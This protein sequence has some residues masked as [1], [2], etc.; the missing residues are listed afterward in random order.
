MA[1][2]PLFTRKFDFGFHLHTPIPDNADLRE[3]DRDILSSNPI[4]KAMKA[5][6]FEVSWQLQKEGQNV[7]SGTI[8]EKDLN[9]RV[10]ALDIQYIFAKR[11]VLLRKGQNYML[12][13]EVT[14]PSQALAAFS[15]ELLIRTWASL[16]GHL[17]V[18]WKMRDTMLCLALGFVL[19]AAGLLRQYSEG[20]RK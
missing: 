9:H 1:F 11:N 4:E 18:G 17:L 16:K 12:V 3:P 10:Q 8:S 20:T 7:T 6:T 13:A 5:E 15:P 14:K 19:I 2:V